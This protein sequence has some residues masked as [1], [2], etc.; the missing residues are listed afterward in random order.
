MNDSKLPMFLTPKQFREHI[1][2]WSD[3][4]LRDK[5]ENDGFP[6][7]NENPGGKRARYSIPTKEA[8]LW[9]K[10]REIKAG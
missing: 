5:I 6:A 1:A 4:K 9:F 2:N 3:D 10:R 8:L 7:I